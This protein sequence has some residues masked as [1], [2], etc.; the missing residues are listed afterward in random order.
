MNHVTPSLGSLT[1]ALCATLASILAHAQ[2][3]QPQTIYDEASSLTG[4]AESFPGAYRVLAD[5]TFDSLPA[6]EKLLFAAELTGQAPPEEVDA[7]V[8]PFQDIR[9]SITYPSGILEFDQE[10]TKEAIRKIKLI[11]KY[12]RL[13]NE[14]K[15]TKDIVPVL[16]HVAKVLGNKSA[17]T[18]P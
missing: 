5:G 16:Q 17:A 15:N 7:S 12:E 1:V 18:T 10:M 11:D 9:D 4:I 13:H 2:D 6:M 8:K 14:Y 3:A